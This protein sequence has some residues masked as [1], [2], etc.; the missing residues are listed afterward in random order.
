MSYNVFKPEGPTNSQK[1]LSLFRLLSHQTLPMIWEQKEVHGVKGEASAILV[2]HL[3]IHFHAP[4]WGIQHIWWL[5]VLGTTVQIFL[6][7]VFQT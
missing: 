4:P 3:F 7:Q 1:I 6:R 2:L 5:M